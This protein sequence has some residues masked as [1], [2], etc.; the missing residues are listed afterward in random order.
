MMEVCR[1]KLS[2]DICSSGIQC[3]LLQYYLAFDISLNEEK[4]NDQ[5]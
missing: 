4:R 2:L 3:E 5:I 1:Y